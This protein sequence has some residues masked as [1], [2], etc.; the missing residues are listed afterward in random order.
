MLGAMLLNRYRLEAE[1]GQGAMGTVYRAQDVLLDR[2]VAIKVLREARLGAEGWAR[3]MHEA[4][5]VARL[6]HPNIIAIY[7]VAATGV[8]NGASSAE[9]L[10]SPAAPGQLF[11]VMELA[12]GETLD[13][14]GTQ[15]LAETLDI[16]LQVCA[17]LDHPPTHGIIHLDLKPDTIA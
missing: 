14:R 13:R 9:P 6:N 10:D 5:A 7:D 16:A 11:I 3:L 15:T 8:T 17:A 2:C 12:E 1:L 4:R